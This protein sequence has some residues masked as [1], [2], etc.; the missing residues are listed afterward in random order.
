MLN[1]NLIVDFSLGESSPSGEK[2]EYLL[3]LFYAY[4]PT[5]PVIS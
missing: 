5:H 2:R 4:K 1:K 3:F